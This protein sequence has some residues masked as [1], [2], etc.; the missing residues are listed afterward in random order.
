[1]TIVGDDKDAFVPNLKE[2]MQALG[3]AFRAS[4][5]IGTY[6]KHEFIA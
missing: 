1:M 4:V 6:E 3:V 2:T 5:K